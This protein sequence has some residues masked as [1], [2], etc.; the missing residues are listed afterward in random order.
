[1]D[2]LSS[3]S[4][5][6]DLENISKHNRP[7]PYLFEPPAGSVKGASNISSDSSTEEDM[8]ENTSYTENWCVYLLRN[9]DCKFMTVDL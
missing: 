6:E 7:Q 9:L 3:G 1:M 5:C 8:Q 4:E 2:G